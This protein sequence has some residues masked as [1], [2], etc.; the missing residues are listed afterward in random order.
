MASNVNENLLAAIEKPAFVHLPQF[1]MCIVENNH[2]N[3]REWNLTES[4]LPTYL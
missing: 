4:S 2:L 3:S 1:Q